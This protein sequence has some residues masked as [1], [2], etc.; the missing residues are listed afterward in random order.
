MANSRSRQV[1]DLQSQIADL[2]Q[3]NMLL[4]K[5]AGVENTDYEPAEQRRRHQEA[6]SEMPPAPQRAAP[7]VMT[8]FDHVRD[9]IREHSRGIFSTSPVRDTAPRETG[10]LQHELPPR[11]DFARLSRAYLDSIHEWYPALHGQR[12]RVR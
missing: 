4:E 12:F 10:S 3:R 6:R 8:N 11:S 2:A 5:A 7:P 9:N 1:Q